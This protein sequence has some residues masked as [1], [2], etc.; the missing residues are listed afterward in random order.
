[1]QDADTA[2]EAARNSVDS[3][4]PYMR[5]RQTFPVLSDDQVKRLTSYGQVEDLPEGTVVFERGQRGVDFFLILSGSI[6]IF[7]RTP[8]G[9]EIIVTTHSDHQFTGELDLFNKRKIL[10]GGRIGEDSRVVR[11]TREQFRRMSSTER[12]HQA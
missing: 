3:S 12:T 2:I 6:D 11:L 10:V 7:D 1:M 4:D 5:E 9:D 8:E